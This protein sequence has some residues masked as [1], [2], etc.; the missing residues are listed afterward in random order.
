MTSCAH[1]P[2]PKGGR[3]QLRE[4]PARC[5]LFFTDE[6]IERLRDKCGRTSEGGAFSR[7]EA[8]CA[9]LAH[10][11]A[12]VLSLSADDGGDGSG[13]GTHHRG[14]TQGDA[15]GDARG[16]PMSLGMVA[17]LR[18]RPSIPHGYLGN[19]AH[20]L[21]SPPGAVTADDVRSVAAIAG[22]LRSVGDRIRTVPGQRKVADEGHC[23]PYPTTHTPHPTPH[24]T[25]HPIH[26]TTTPHT[27]HPL[28]HPRSPTIGCGKLASS[29]PGSWHTSPRKVRSKPFTRTLTRTNY[30]ARPRPRPTPA[31]T[32]NP[33][34]LPYTLPHFHTSHTSTLPRGG[35]LNHHQLPTS[36]TDA[37]IRGGVRR[38]G[39]VP[40][41]AFYWRYGPH[42]PLS[43]RG[44]GIL[45]PSRRPRPATQLGRC[46]KRASRRGPQRRIPM[47][48]WAATGGACVMAVHMQT[49]GRG[50]QLE[51]AHGL[52]YINFRTGIGVGGLY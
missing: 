43:G 13:S 27:P 32:G 23:T 49:C 1:H 31:P 25:P 18:G 39:A 30:H 35:P 34:Y 44:L 14:S 20:L 15:R 29:S 51:S 46:R 24:Q 4:R 19:T 26:H 50:S 21:T 36:N 3:S 37:R 33:P 11:A 22:H 7:N 38:R 52:A 8:L 6:S 47:P 10:G 42:H 2:T 17:D 41:G 5:H 45:E 48:L 9:Y 16:S 12:R 28:P 40:R